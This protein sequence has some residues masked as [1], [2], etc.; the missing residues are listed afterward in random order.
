AVELDDARGA[1]EES[2]EVLG[3]PLVAVQRALRSAGVYSVEEVQEGRLQRRVRGVIGRS[4]QLELPEALARDADVRR[5][6]R[7]AVAAPLRVAV[8]PPPRV[9][10][11]VEPSHSARCS[12][13]ASHRSI[14]PSG[15]RS[16]LRI[17]TC[18]IESRTIR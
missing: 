6:E 11:L 5:A 8:V 2:H 12:W 10:P 9:A 13:A 14:S 7:L 1:A 15:T 17:Q 16:S 4:S 18:V 3:L